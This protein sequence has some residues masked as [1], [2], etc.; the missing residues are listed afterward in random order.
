MRVQSGFANPRVLTV[1]LDGAVSDS[2]VFFKRLQGGSTSWGDFFVDAPSNKVNAQLTGRVGAMH[3]CTSAAQMGCFQ[4][5]MSGHMVYKRETLAPIAPV[6]PARGSY[7]VN[8][9]V[10]GGDGWI[11]FGQWRVPG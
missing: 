7:Y 1:I 2:L 10:Q 8:G 11:Q 3:K 5:R 4:I 9:G 6:G